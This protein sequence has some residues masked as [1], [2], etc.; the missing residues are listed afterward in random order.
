[1]REEERMRPLAWLHEIERHGAG[2]EQL[3]EESGSLAVS[4]WRVARARCAAAQGGV[5]T[6]RQL[7]TVARELA[8]RVGYFDAVLSE[9]TLASECV[10]RGLPVSAQINPSAT[11]AGA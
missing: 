7:Y 2:L 3:F 10:R 6:T 1:M 5:P 8:A 11:H 4:A 9:A